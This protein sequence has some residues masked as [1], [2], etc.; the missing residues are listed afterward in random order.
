MYVLTLKRF[1]A[2]VM[3]FRRPQEAH[4]GDAYLLFYVQRGVTLANTMSDLVHATN[5]V[6]VK[7]PCMMGCFAIFPGL[8]PIQIAK[9]LL[10]GCFCTQS[11]MYEMQVV[12]L[13]GDVSHGYA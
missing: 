8:T 6:C 4:T 13:V 12:D 1:K 10:V 3:S 9:R 7:G 5:S 2:L 11:I